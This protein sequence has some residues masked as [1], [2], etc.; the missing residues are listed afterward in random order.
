MVG[1]PNVVVAAAA[2]TSPAV[3]LDRG[4]STARCAL[5]DVTADGGAAVS[6][7]LPTRGGCCG[8]TAALPGRAAD[9]MRGGS[10]CRPVAATAAGVAAGVAILPVAD[11]AAAAGAAG[12][13]A[14]G[15][16]PRD[17]STTCEPLPTGTSTVTPELLLPPVASVAPPV[18]SSVDGPPWGGDSDTEV[19]GGSVTENAG[20]AATGRTVAPPVRGSDALLRRVAATLPSL[21]TAAPGGRE[22]GSG[23]LLRSTTTVG[24]DA[25]AVRVGGCRG[26]TTAPVGSDERG[27][28]SLRGGAGAPAAGVPD[29][30]SA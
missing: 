22:R 11:G 21:G 9:G 1:A 12:E 16:A 29:D 13:G 26:D 5:A 7:S 28:P 2:P 8:D 24:D 3:G 27:P 6:P 15:A 30:G 25:R 17:D 18:V 19:P 14:K 4:A 20:V 10:E 23:A